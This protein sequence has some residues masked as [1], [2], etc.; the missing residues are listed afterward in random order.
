MAGLKQISF[1][2]DAPEAATAPV[3]KPTDAAAVIAVDEP[4][5]ITAIE[6]AA[7]TIIDVDFSNPV[8]TAA[9]PKRKKLHNKKAPVAA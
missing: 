2:F 6:Q 5:P 9:A 8:V 1:D 7:A 4:V 3:A